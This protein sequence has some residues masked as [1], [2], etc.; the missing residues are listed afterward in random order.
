MNSETRYRRFFDSANDGI[1]LLDA[2]TGLIT[3]INPFLTQLLHY[4]HDELVG[5]AI[6]DLGLVKDVETSKARFRELVAKSYVRYEDLPFR[7][8]DGSAISVEVSG[9]AYRVKGEEVVQCNIRDIRLRKDAELSEQ[10]LR[11]SH[12]MEA[13]G[14]LA[15]GLTH[16]FNNLLGV[17]L[18]YC[19]LIEAQEALPEP[20][21]IMVVEIHNA[22][23]SAK[24]LSQRLLAFGRRQVLLLV[25]LDLNETVN[26][27]QTMLGRLIRDDVA[28]VSVLS[29]DLGNIKADSSQMEQILMNL[30]INARDAMPVGGNIT[31]ETTNIV[32]DATTPAQSHPFAPPGRYVKLTVTDTGVGMDLET[33]TRIF[34]PFFSTKAPGQGSGLGLATV[35]GIVE[36][37]GG[38]IVVHSQPGE[39]TSFQIYFPRCHEAPAAVQAQPAKPSS[40]GTETILLVDDADTLKGGESA[41]ALMAFYAFLRARMMQASVTCSAGI[42]EATIETISSVRTAWQQIDTRPCEAAEKPINLI[43]SLPGAAQEI[44]PERVPF[45]MSG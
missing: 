45:S 27:M 19:E 9:N 12:K 36:Q 29:P 34:E 16:D 14:Q 31:I 18:G 1:L 39:G 44:E 7:N 11:H 32:I 35:F 23:K 42:L 33:Q 10:R 13:V 2:K 15:G 38:A 3:D 40:R 43:S 20:T 41:L 21:R 30:V 8:K 22:G 17:I 26:R 25:P 5:K 24:N 37:S 4:S 6:W 28:L